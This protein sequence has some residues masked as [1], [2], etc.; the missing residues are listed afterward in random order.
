[1][2]ALRTT[3]GYHP[4]HFLG[5]PKLQSF[6]QPGLQLIHIFTDVSLQDDPAAALLN[7]TPLPRKWYH[8]SLLKHLN[9]ARAYIPCMWKQKSI[10]TV[11]QWLARVDDLEQMENLTSVLLEKSEEHWDLYRFSDK[12]LQYS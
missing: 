9:A 12:F 11:A 4:A 2:L 6:W 5:M 1:M 10:R 8:N 3:N 7:L